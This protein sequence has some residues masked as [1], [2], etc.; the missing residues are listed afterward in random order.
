[1]SRKSVRAALLI[2]VILSLALAGASVAKGPPPDKPPG[3]ETTATN[4]LSY[5]AIAVDGFSITPIPE[6]TFTVPYAGTYP[7]LTAEEIAYLE[8]NGPWYAQ[9]VTENKWQAESQ[10]AGTA[11]VTYIDWSDNIES[12]NPKMN[13]PFRLEMV[14]FKALETPMTAY[15]MAVLEYPSSSNELQGTNTS[16]YG[17]YYATVIS[18]KPQLV[19]QYLGA[20]VPTDLTWLGTQWSSGSVVA[21]TFQPELNVGGKWV[22]GASSGGWKPSST[23]WYR[24][25]FYVP[26]TGSGVNLALGTIANAATGF[27]APTEGV[28]TAVLDAENNLTYIDVKVL[29]KGGGGGRR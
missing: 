8:A 13:T 21:V 17:S 9:K 25:T 19:V 12:V 7:G 11:D 29:P 14:L 20:T 22:F 15:T 18:S 5:P 23:G 3:G 24:L 2:A 26:A 4:N 1:M 27:A 10:N 16:T 28:A 6:T